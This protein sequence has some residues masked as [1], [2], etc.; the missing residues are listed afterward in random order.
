MKEKITGT[1]DCPSSHP[2][3]P[4]MAML[5]DSSS[6]LPRITGPVSR[7]AVFQNFTRDEIA[8]VLDCLQGTVRQF[9]RREIIFRP[10]EV[11][12]SIG[13]ILEGQVLHSMETEAGTR[14]I[15]SELSAGDVIG[16]NALSADPVHGTFEAGPGERCEILFIKIRKIVRPDQTTCTMRGRV[17]ENIMALILE[18]NR[19]LSRKLD[20]VS[21]KSL[22]ERVLHFLGTY[23]KRMNSRSFSIPFSR[24]DMADYLMVDRSALSRELQ[25]MKM[26][27]LIDVSGKDF[28]LYSLDG[29]FH[30]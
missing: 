24:S 12:D 22:R 8:R 16:E 28:T 19:R 17:I 26:D 14:T 13:I 4:A 30:L 15:V 23:A 27:G 7:A 10:E 18:N 6:G 3:V 20:L 29:Q 9:G 25:R 11:L 1:S 5:L 2:H 21:Y